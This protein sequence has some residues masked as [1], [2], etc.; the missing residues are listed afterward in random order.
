MRIVGTRTVRQRLQQTVLA[1]SPKLR[2]LLAAV[3]AAAWLGGVGSEAEARLAADGGSLGNGTTHSGTIASAGEVDTWT[4]AANAGDRIAVH[5]GEIAD[6]NDFRPWIRLLAPGG[7]TVGESSGTGAAVIDDVVAPTTGTYL[8]LVASLDPG[9]DGTG[10]YRLTMA[11]TR[12]KIT[13]SPGDEGGPLTNGAL[14]GGEVVKG[15][16][17]VWTFKAKAGQRIA[18]HIGEIVD[19]DDFRP[20]IRLWAP[21]GASLDDTSGTGAAVIDDVVAPTTGTYLVLVA[22]L[23]PGFDGTGTYRLTMTHTPGPIKVSA[24]DQGGPLKNGALHSGEIL[25]GDVDVWR[26][27]ATAGQRIALHIG[28]IVDNDDFRPWIRLWA[29]NGASL[30]DTSGTGAA[31]IDDVV[32]P[33]T[34]TYLVLVASLDPGFDGTGTYRLTMTHT[35]GPITVSPGDQGGPLT[36]GAEHAGEIPKGDVD[37][38]TITATAGSD[39][40]VNVRETSDADDFRPW[41]RLWAPDG[42]SLGDA[43]GTADAQISTTATVTGTY[44]VLVASLNPGFAG[45]GTYSLRVDVTP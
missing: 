27:K 35:P 9:F 11:H 22:S 12:G 16:V 1:V 4:F 23:D 37:V 45:T 18:L 8:V 32:A 26:F 38:W 31:V 40:V 41:I 20:W 5:I 33:T 6:D 43:S 10:T 34:G 21:T 28:E 36:N 25:K 29:P 7:S 3:V 17:D 30:G 19:N 2:W 14:H 24:G 13:V 15:D 44:L 39:I 42:A